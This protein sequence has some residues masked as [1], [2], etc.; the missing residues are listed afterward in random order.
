MVSLVLLLL[1]W[2][3]E[4]VPLDG[5]C[6]TAD[7]CATAA[8]VEEDGGSAKEFARTS[9]AVVAGTAAATATTAAA[10][11]DDDVRPSLLAVNGSIFADVCLDGFVDGFAVEGGV[12]L[13]PPPSG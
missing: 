10:A 8:A 1:F 3:E 2:E 4:G 7:R 12:L 13:L 6:G 5:G 11:D 9:R